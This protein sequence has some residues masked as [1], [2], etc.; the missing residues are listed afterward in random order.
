M[1]KPPDP[2][3]GAGRSVRPR[4]GRAARRPLRP[5]HAGAGGRRRARGARAEHIVQLACTVF[6]TE[7]ALVALL[8]GERIFIRNA[9]G[10]FAPGDFPWRYS[11]C[12]YTLVPKNPTA[13]VIEDAREDARCARGAPPRALPAGPARLRGVREGKEGCRPRA[14]VGTPPGAPLV[15]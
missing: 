5:R 11:F 15:R 1:D 7:N 13:M 4:L 8:E 9:T 2:E 3:I 10:S 6:G 12:G 14:R